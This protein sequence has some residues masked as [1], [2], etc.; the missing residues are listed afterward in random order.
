MSNDP[1]KTLVE[2]KAVE[3]PNTDRVFSFDQQDTFI[4][5][6]AKDC[7]CIVKDDQTFSRH[8]MLLEIN[9]ANVTL[10]DLGSLNGTKLNGVLHGGRN[11]SVAPEDAESSSPVA[12]RDGDR[13]KAGANVFLLHIDAPAICVDCSKEI[14]REKRKAAEFINGTYLCQDCRRKEDEKQK[15]PKSEKKVED[16]RMGAKQRQKADINPAAVIDELFRELLILKKDKEKPM[17]IQGYRNLKKIGEGGFGAVYRAER[18]SDG[19][20]VAVKTMLQTRKPPAKQI[21]MFE[22]EKKVAEQLKHKNIVLTSDAGVWNDI[23]FIE[24]EFV[25]GGCVYSRMNSG[26]G[27]FSLKEATPIMLDVLEGLSY[28]HSAKITVDTKKGQKT[29]RGVVHRDLKPP[30]ILLASENGKQVAKISDF[31][32]AKA[33]ATA[34]CT[35]GSITQGQGTFCGSPPY[36]AREHIIN[37]RYVKPVTDVFEIA[38]TFFHM[39][40]GETVWP[41]RAG[42]DLYKIILESRPRRLKDHLSSAPKKLYEVFDQALEIEISHRFQDAGNFLKAIK[43]VL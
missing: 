13:I 18:V 25:E 42:S 20:I 40:T 26:A 9:Q 19:K 30:N 32:L 24:M 4:L 21:R 38:A 31:G 5:G 39:L 23:H 33:F 28:A 36:M 6:R 14:T 2:L 27:V 35:Q 43:R 8:H 17:E 37:Y 1:Q 16:I 10:K 12:L 29:V 3:G 41:M 22:R 7:S 15:K 11:K 34:G